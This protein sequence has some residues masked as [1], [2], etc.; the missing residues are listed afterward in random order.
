MKKSIIIAVTFFIVCVQSTYPQISTN[1]LPISVQRGLG[2][3]TK[4]KTKGI[5]DL[6]VPDIKKVLQEDSLNQERNPNGLKRTAVSIP[7][8]VDSNNDG[9]WTTLDSGG[10]L[11]QM[12]IHVTTSK[13]QGPV[14]IEKG[15]VTNKCN[16]TVV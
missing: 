9:V 10:R 8:I 7:I 2:V 15:K 16:G 13:P 3:F 12:E 14:S 11:W 6:P 4:D 5:V 1:E